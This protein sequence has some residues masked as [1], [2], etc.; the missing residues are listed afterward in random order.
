V[1]RPVVDALAERLYADL[2]PLAYADAANGWPLL[3][4]C[5][6]LGQLIQP[7][8]DLARDTTAG[9]GWSELLDVTRTP[10]DALPWLAQ[11]VGVRLDPALTESAQRTQIQEETGM[12][13]GT[14]AAM[15]AA[16][17]KLLTG[18]KT[19]VF[20]ERYPDPYS[21]T[22]IT[23]TS[24]T[25]DA[26]AVEAALRAA[27]PAGLILTYASV[28]GQL[29]LQVVASYAHWSNVISTFATW[30]DVINNTP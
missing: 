16:A 20:L 5:G 14:P 15:R 28:T 23:Y 25:P 8:D 27:K 1:T 3:T 12:K 26:A 6:A 17:Q 10:A 4:L 22:V 21:L 19:V 29:W 24:E 2:T 18:S 9:P 30:Q 7:V 13:R 11:F